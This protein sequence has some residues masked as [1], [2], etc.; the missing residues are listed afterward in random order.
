MRP[1]AMHSTVGVDG[2]H[3]IQ[4]PHNPFAG[5]DRLSQRTAP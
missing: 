3:P 5:F 4:R 2:V 1:Y